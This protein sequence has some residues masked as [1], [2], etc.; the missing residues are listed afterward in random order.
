MRRRP[1]LLFSAKV[2][3][4][5]A[6]LAA[7]LYTVDF[8]E[9]WL[10]AKN[11]RV[12]LLLLA[13]GMFFPTQ[14]LSA[15]RWYYLL[16]ILGARLSYG[17]VVRY[18]FLGQFSALFLPGQIS[19]DIVRATAI[20]QK[21]Q[22]YA[23]SFLSLL[24]DKLTFLFAISLFAFIGAQSSPVLAHFPGLR[25][26][27]AAIAALS[28]AGVILC[29]MYRDR[30]LPTWLMGL[31]PKTHGIL[32]RGLK[33][34]VGLVAVPRLSI[35]AIT[36]MVLCALGLQVVNTV[37]SYVLARSMNVMVAPLDWMAVNAVVAIIQILPISIGGLGV[38]EGTFVFLL[39]FYG[40]SASHALAFSLITFILVAL[41]V[42][43]G[44]IVVEAFAFQR[45]G[46]LS[47]LSRRGDM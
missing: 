43:L 36:W 42:T 1:A 20:A 23:Q 47:K 6:L 10:A 7:L 11:I 38:R 5:L 15:Y 31:W 39:S 37:G 17:T 41:L 2:L 45:G 27:S 30:R 21:D 14:L 3:F 19:G 12:G 9:L 40:V 28:L 8:A 4:S 33:Q 18:T 22:Q 13:V 32:A 34:I 26:A 16:R 24:L 29:A 44:W 25:I 35:S 46:R